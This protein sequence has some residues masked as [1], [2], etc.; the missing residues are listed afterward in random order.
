MDFEQHKRNFMQQKMQE[1]MMEQVSSKILEGALAEERRLDEQLA[2]AENLDED[3]F[4][5]LR[6]KRKLDLQKK[7]RQEMDW[8]QLGHGKRMFSPSCYHAQYS[9]FLFK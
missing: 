8:R 4:E 5:T 1:K 2:K 3:D 6:Q 7:A 9:R